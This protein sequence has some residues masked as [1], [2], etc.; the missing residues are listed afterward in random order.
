MSDEHRE[1]MEFMEGIKTHMD[2]CFA[3]YI[4]VG[5][6]VFGDVG[7]IINV[8]LQ[9]QASGMN[10]ERIARMIGELEEIKLRMQLES[11]GVCF[12]CECQNE[13]RGK[14]FHRGRVLRGP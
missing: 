10:R 9:E 4:V 7:S 12:D 11:I 8:G 6:D 1:K 5:I 3:D 13:T 2:E 14:T